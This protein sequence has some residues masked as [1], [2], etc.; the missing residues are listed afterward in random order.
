MKG[1]SEG[2]INKWMP[3]KSLIKDVTLRNDDLHLFID[4]CFSEK[5]ILI[6]IGSESRKYYTT[7]IF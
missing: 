3:S 7:I 6:Y 2:S 5:H 1:F 4:P